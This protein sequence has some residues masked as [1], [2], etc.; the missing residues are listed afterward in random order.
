MKGENNDQQY[1]RTLR[2]DSIIPEMK[3]TS[4]KQVIQKLSEHTSHLIGTPQRFL[5]E[6]LSD[7][8]HKQSSGIGQGVAIAHMRL[9][10]LTRSMVVF[11][12]LSRPIDFNA[13]DEQPVDLVC[14]VLSPE[15]EGPKHLS[16]L[17]KV[18]RFFSDKSFCDSLRDAKDAHDIRLILKEINSRKM[19]A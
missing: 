18:S 1:S 9:P 11:S 12:K 15:F 10:R 4:S 19:A 17:A 5:F 2:F 7:Q 3:V 13:I 8:E 6:T 14:L 16:R